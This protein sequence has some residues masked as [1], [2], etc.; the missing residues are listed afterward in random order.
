MDY[1]RL[2]RQDFRLEMLLGLGRSSQVYLARAPD[3]TQVALKVPR[4]EVRTDK[5]LTERFA[6]EVAL[7]LTLSHPNLVRGLSGRPEGEG[8]FLALEYF[9]DGTLEDL[10]KKGPLSREMALDCLTQ[11]AQALLYLHE[12]GIVHQDVKPSNI[13]VDGTRF[14][15]GDFGVAKTRE[16]PKPLERAG[17]PFYMAPEL[18]LGEPATPASDAYSFGVMAFELLVGKRP[19][20]GESLEELTYAHLHKLPP[21]THLP[22]HLDRI[23][24][25]LLAKD[26]AIRATLKAF[27]QTV[28]SPPAPP[29]QPSKAE[30]GE[31]PQRS[32]G[33][34]RLF[35]KR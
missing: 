8:A 15:L 4:R 16:N 18:F 9:P 5:A 28:L 12:R 7:S 11:V 26:P 1:R 27:L 21:P 23:L 25:N 22:P 31:K 32:R 35:R 14:K 6:Q 34:F 17:S 30:K 10:L 33:I 24:R 3:G 20:L 2:T 13:F 29:A 19:F